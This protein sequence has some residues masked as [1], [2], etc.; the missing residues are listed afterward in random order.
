MMS[1]VIVTGASSGIGA[2]V[3]ER[4]FHEGWTVHAWDLEPGTGATG[5]VV[6]GV[7]EVLAGGTG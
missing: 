3:A 4:F 2:A 5:E 6:A 7:D 1:T